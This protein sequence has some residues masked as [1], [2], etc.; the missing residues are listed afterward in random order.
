MLEYNH[1]SV[2]LN[3]VRNIILALLCLFIFVSCGKFRA[4]QP[5]VEKIIFLRNDQNL[6]LDKSNINL[7]P[8]RLPIA[9]G[10]DGSFENPTP[11]T[12]ADTTS[13]PHRLAGKLNLYTNTPNG[14]SGS[15][16][17]ATLIENTNVAITAAHCVYTYPEGWVD[18][19]EFE[20][21]SGGDS[22]QT[23]GW[24][25]AAIKNL[26]VN[27]NPGRRISRAQSAVDVAFVLLSNSEVS[28]LK[29]ATGTPSS[30]VSISGYPSKHFS[31]NIMVTGVTAL[32][33]PQ[34]GALIS[35]I[36]MNG[37]SSGSSWINGNNI[38]GVLSAGNGSG[39]VVGAPIDQFAK[40][41]EDFVSRDCPEAEGQR[42]SLYTPPDANQILTAL[43]SATSD[44]MPMKQK[45]R[46]LASQLPMS[47]L[48]I[49][50]NP[51]RLTGQFST[52][53]S[54]QF[55]QNAD[56]LSC[57]FQCDQQSPLCNSVAV[58]FDYGEEINEVAD[59]LRQRR[60]IKKAEMMEIFRQAEDGCGRGDIT[61]ADDRFENTGSSTSC[62]ASSTYN[63]GTE[64]DPQNIT[65][66]IALPK[67]V[68]GSILFKG[69]D[70]GATFDKGS[71]PGL[72]FDNDP[73]SIYSGLLTNITTHK[74]AFVATLG[75]ACLFM[76]ASQ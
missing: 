30:P 46:F 35:N 12:P 59:L 5:L 18:D 74:N 4:H 41:I 22:P 65:L 1:F 36:D 25:C 27:S 61:V 32:G 56:N 54:I 28:Q 53:K 6:A 2:R 11:V 37:G 34:N 60:D 20:L 8:R 45:N 43:A 49:A 72:L 52:G 16:C 44:R 23:Y 75:G 50:F 73:N 70:I 14:V 58:P 21:R 10:L 29:P 38:H 17:S 40:R 7:N 48:K 55:V 57:T 63:V 64:T 69:N 9:K 62:V 66:D 15:W 67:K 13:L 31:G 71:E 51:G 26:W 47:P 3:T 39:L 24:K 68:F 33:T 76:G 19:M 42:A